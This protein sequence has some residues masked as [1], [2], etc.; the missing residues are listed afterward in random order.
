MNTLRREGEVMSKGDN[1]LRHLGEPI[2]AKCGGGL[3]YEGDAPAPDDIIECENAKCGRK[4][5]YAEVTAD[6]EA[7]YAQFQ[8]W[9][10][11][12]SALG[13]PTMKEIRRWKPKGKRKFTMKIVGAGKAGDLKRDFKAIEL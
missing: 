7:I 8:D 6:C 3:I 2:C 12:Q 1:G 9:Y 13:G 11:Q 4:G 5:T 10:L